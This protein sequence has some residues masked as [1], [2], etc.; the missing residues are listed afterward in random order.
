M[1]VKYKISAT[2]YDKRMR[3]IAV[4]QNSY[5]K[6]HPLMLHFASKV[7][8]HE[9][10]FLHAE[11]QALLRCGDSVPYLLEVTRYTKDGNYANARP[12]PVCYEACKAFGVK[13]IRYSNEFG[14]QMEI[15]NAG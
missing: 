5:S 8:L 11:V 3:K 6:T 1:K 14:L 13:V 7:N 4:G 15:V 12:C 2:V 10:I 9:K